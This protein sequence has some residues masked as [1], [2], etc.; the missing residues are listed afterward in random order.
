MS[1]GGERLSLSDLDVFFNPK[2]VAIVGASQIPTKIGSVI[3]VNFMESNFRGKVYPI[4]P[5]F[6]CVF[7]IQCW[8]S[9]LN[10]P[11]EID[12]SVIA[13]PAETVPRIMEE[14]A[15]K[16]VRGAIIIS[17]GFSEIGE[18][19]RRREQKIL[20]IA[21][22]AGMRVIGPNCVGVYDPVSGVDT[23]FMPRFR[24]SRPGPGRIA[25]I[26]QSGAFGV[27]VLDWAAS[28]GFGVS[29][30]ISI[31]NKVDVNEIDL[32]EYLA[33]DPMTQVIAL[34]MEATSDGRKLIEVAREVV[35]KKPIVVLKAGA[36]AEG[37]RAVMS[38][39]GSLAGSDQ[40]YDAAFRQ[41]GIVRASD[42]Q[43]LFDV[44]RA[45]ATQPIPKGNRVA[46]V[47]NGGGFAVLATDA[48]VRYGLQMAKLS[49]ETIE[50]L[51]RKLPPITAKANPIDLVG[52]AD[53][54]RYRIALEAVLRD[55]NVD[56]VLVIILFQTPSL[57]PDIVEVVAASAVT[58]GKPV[59]V[60]STGGEFTRAYVHMLERANI[61]VYPSPKRAARAMAVLMRY[62]EIR[63]K[64]AELPT[65]LQVSR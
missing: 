12:L 13:T 39:T 20:E 3:Y 42:P 16:G 53:A 59:L 32:I 29:K 51:E 6:K 44:A 60:C 45:L 47:S 49:P 30:F 25:F 1:I 61:P 37:G 10:V 9:V 23:V 24:M 52:D 40:I 62:G 2:S 21:R 19:G 46:V 11:D 63:R 17:G 58:Y 41:C 22:K 18:E 5:R 7:G 8:P 38:H 65:P 34:Y 48:L 57:Q 33:Q 26:S 36:T 15:E 64:F 54:E 31:G 27:A 55:E 43:D 56:G 14:C 50:V 4:N 28:R 35:R